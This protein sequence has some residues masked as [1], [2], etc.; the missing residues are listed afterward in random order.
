MPF[1]SQNNPSK[2][3]AFGVEARKETER[4]AAK[5]SFRKRSAEEWALGVTKVAPDGVVLVVSPQR[6]KNV[7]NSVTS[8]FFRSLSRRRRTQRSSAERRHH[9]AIQVTKLRSMSRRTISSRAVRHDSGVLIHHAR[10]EDRQR[11]VLSQLFRTS[12]VEKEAFFSKIG[13]DGGSI[14]GSTVCHAKKKVDFHVTF[15]ELRKFFD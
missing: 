3:N 14:P 11:L 10:I 6:G 7:G 2:A 4:E 8:N 12:S 5:R 9:A 15:A 13:H 1:S